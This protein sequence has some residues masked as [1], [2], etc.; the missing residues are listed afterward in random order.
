MENAIYYNGKYN[1]LYWKI[2]IIYITSTIEK[3]NCL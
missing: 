2:N 1:I 3:I